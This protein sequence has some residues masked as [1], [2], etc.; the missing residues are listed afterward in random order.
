MALSA[1]SQETLDPLR[2]AEFSNRCL[3]MLVYVGTGTKPNMKISEVGDRRTLVKG[4][5][6]Q[7]LAELATNA[8]RL[9]WLERVLSQ[10]PSQACSIRRQ[11][12][13]GCL[14]F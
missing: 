2:T 5:L 11:P 1:S 14:R 13:D 10:G 8:M 12:I 7:R 4:V 6:R 9:A 3:D